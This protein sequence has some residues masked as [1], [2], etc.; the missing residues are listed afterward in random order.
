MPFIGWLI[1]CG[2]YIG[3][4]LAQSRV[5]LSPCSMISLKDTP[6]L[7]KRDKAKALIKNT[8]RRTPDKLQTGVKGAFRQSPARFQSLVK[9]SFR[10]PASCPSPPPTQPAPLLPPPLPPMSPS[11]AAVLTFAGQPASSFELTAVQKI[12]DGKG[13]WCA[14]EPANA[15]DGSWLDGLT[16]WDVLRYVRTCAVGSSGEGEGDDDA[17][18]DQVIADV[19]E[20]ARVRLLSTARWRKEREVCKLIASGEFDMEPFFSKRKRASAPE[21][22]DGE[23]PQGMPKP[24]L[25]V[26][27]L[28]GRDAFGR[29]TAIFYADRHTPGEIPLDDWDDFVIYS[30]ETAVVRFGLNRGPGGQFNLLVDRSSSGLRNQD[31]SLALSILPTI[32][33]HYPGLLGRVVVA[34]I[35]PIFYAAWNVVKLFLK[36]RTIQKFVFIRGSDWRAQLKDVIGGN[37]TLPAHLM[38]PGLESEL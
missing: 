19:A 37:V 9:T 26:E 17:S 31:V 11:P 8:F 13:E 27:W 22:V 7:R 28:A 4:P 35:N 1:A 6:R 16:D 24:S 18:R 36:P 10:G 2:A 21:K 29:A 15:V 32:Q 3:V 20:A 5:C 14:R 23:G 33:D 25:E 30:A 12:V 34:P 38:P